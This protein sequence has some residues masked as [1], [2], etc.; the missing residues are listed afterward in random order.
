[1][2]I[3]RFA[4]TFCKDDCL[5]TLRLNLLDELSSFEELSRQQVLRATRKLMNDDGEALTY[6]KMQIEAEKV[7]Y[8]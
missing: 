6:F 3:E 8:V 2:N 7:E 1:M 5:T 4:N